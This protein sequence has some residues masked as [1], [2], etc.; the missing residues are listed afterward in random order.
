MGISLD[1]DLIPYACHVDDFTVITKNGFLLQTICF[2]INIGD[3]NGFRNEIRNFIIENYSNEIGLYFHTI[4]ISEY[5]DLIKNESKNFEDILSQKISKICKLT[6]VNEISFNVTFIRKVIQNGNGLNDLFSFSSRAL[7]KKYETY[8]KQCMR[9]LNLITDEMLLRFK[10]YLPIKLGIKESNGFYESLH[11]NFLGK[12]VNFRNERYE[13]AIGGLCYA[14]NYSSHSFGNRVIKVKNEY[15]SKYAKIFSLKEYSEVS[16][17]VIYRMLQ[18][19]ENIIISQ[20]ILPV[21]NKFLLKHYKEIARIYQS[22]SDKEFKESSALTYMTELMDSNGDKNVYSRCQLNIVVIGETNE[23]LNESCK[24]ISDIFARTGIISFTEDI[25][26]QNAFYSIMPGNFKFLTRSS[27][28]PTGLVAGFAYAEGSDRIDS[29][30]FMWGKSLVTLQ[31]INNRRYQIGMPLEQRNMVIIGKGGSG[32]SMLANIIVAGCVK[33]KIS[34]YYIDTTEKGDCFGMLLG[35]RLERISFQ[36]QSD[37]HS[38]FNPFSGLR[39]KKSHIEYVKSMI[40]IMINNNSGEISDKKID[41]LAKLVISN[42]GS[43]FSGAITDVGL[44]DDMIDWLDIGRNGQVFNY[45]INNPDE[46]DGVGTRVVLDENIISNKNILNVISWALLFKISKIVASGKKALIV[47]KDPF[48]LFNQSFSK[49]LLEQI[50]QR[51]RDENNVSF[52]FIS[53]CNTD[54]IENSYARN[55]ILKHGEIRIH[56]GNDK[57]NDQYKRVFGISGKE[58]ELI[59]GLHKNYGRS[60]AV[61]TPYQREYIKFDLSQL[62]TDLRI[63]SDSSGKAKEILI[64]DVIGNGITS[65][66]DMYDQLVYSLENYKNE[67]DYE[68]EEIDDELEGSEDVLADVA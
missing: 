13:I 53:K 57:I 4:K 17:D 49:G 63:L 37:G 27:N 68:K 22:S 66:D 18:G 44:Q 67:D 26:L 1:N 46:L 40:R 9:K 61:F 2:N 23:K 19:V 64:D 6:A 28:V 8:I 36:G 5:V 41:E 7:Y 3:Q 54:T 16:C 32:R 42:G 45:E 52:I 56:F 30:N 14:T 47:I 51:A 24:V 50:L 11:M 31:N 21:D 48:T 33:N 55:V 12:L 38:G 10:D 25:N 65:R 58:A 20:A 43:D 59:S 34:T 60:F 39:A 62:G 35:S 15:G 29:N